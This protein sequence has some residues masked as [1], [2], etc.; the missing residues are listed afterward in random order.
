VEHEL[1]RQLPFARVVRLD[2]D[3]ATGAAGHEKVLSRFAAG[4]AD[5][6]LGTQMVAKGLHFPNVTLVGVLRADAGL[7]VPDFR[8]AER[9]FTLLSQVIGRAGRGIWPGRAI[10]AAHAPEHYA[11]R[12]AVLG[13]YDLFLT[14]ELKQRRIGNW[15]PYV[16]LASLVFSGEKPD[17]ALTTAEKTKRAVLSALGEGGYDERVVQLLGPA[18]A[19]LQRLAGRWRFQVLVKASSGAALSRGVETA[20]RTGAGGAVRLTVDVDP[21]SLM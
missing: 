12:A 13:D 15:P 21:V 11:V 9:T 7:A 3:A 18:P 14:E 1:V 16:R 17:A 6:L 20:L 4:Q 19:P 2:T 8:A 10:L 5:I